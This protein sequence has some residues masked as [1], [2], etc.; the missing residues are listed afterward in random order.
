MSLFSSLQQASNSLSAAQIGLQVTGNNISNANTPDYLRQRV[1]YTP[2]PTQVHGNLRLGMGVQVEA[3]VQQLDKF[4]EERLQSSISDLSNGEAQ[5][6][7]FLQLEALIGELSDTDISTS[8]NSFFGSISDILNQP[9]D[10]GVRNLSILRGQTL[11]EDV[12]RTYQRVEQVH[13][14]TNNRIAQAGADIKNLLIDIGELNKKIIRMEAGTTRS[15]AVGLRDQRQRS[16]KELSQLIGIRSVEQENGSVTVFSDGDFLVFGGTV[17]TVSTSIEATDSGLQN[18]QVVIDEIESPLN[19]GTGKLAGLITSRDAILGNFLEELDGFA[20]TLIFEFN[21]TFSSGQGL[22][23]YEEMESEFAINVEDINQ[24]LD[25]VGL[26]FTPT[27]GSF[28][29]QVLNNQTGLTNSTDILVKLNGLDDDTSL[30][31]LA[32]EFSAVDGLTASI[33]LDGKLSIETDSPNIEFA[34][35]NDTSGA[36]A[37]LGLG[38]FFQGGNASTINVHDVIQNDAA[39]FAVS[40]GG[41]GADTENAVELASFLTKE[42][43]SIN[44]ETLEFLHTRLVGNVTQSASVAKSV[45]EGFRVFK[46]TL[47]GQKFGISGVS[48][49]E[50]AVKMITYQRQFQASSRLIAAIDELLEVLINI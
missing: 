4:L 42:L 21:K 36:L 34:F 35:A 37:A 12:K 45:A 43:D 10:L 24:S 50:E 17:R 33:G 30:Q 25:Q 3:V 49:D 23:G 28:R 13:S 40:K 48:L 19:S 8:L 39:K 15:D 29:I 26:D 9:E 31:S 22:V 46:E 38:T 20:Q 11:A 41:I 6:N 7:T 18:V 44:G 5:E 16:L 14:D 27:N 32:D 2:A 47:E 1:I